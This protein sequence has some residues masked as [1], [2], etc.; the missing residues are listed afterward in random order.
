MDFE[1]YSYIVL[2]TLDV[3]T[4][5]NFKTFRQRIP[6]RLLRMAHCFRQEMRDLRG[7]DRGLTPSFKRGWNTKK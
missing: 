3:A 4:V 7:Q 5:Y 2:G 6:L 1:D